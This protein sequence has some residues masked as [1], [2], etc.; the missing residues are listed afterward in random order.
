MA[1]ITIARQMGS[2]GKE[3]G[4]K[5]ASDWGY[6]Y[7]HKELIAEIARAAKVPE[8]RVE[9]MDEKGEGALKRF[10]KELFT[11]SHIFPLS[12]EYPAA[13]W[14]YIAASELIREQDSEDSGAQFLDRE[15]YLSL[16]RTTVTKLWERD[17]VII[18]GRGGQ[19]IL[20]DKANA[21]HVLIIAP[22]EVR[23]ERVMQEM[24]INR[25]D[26]LELLQKTDHQRRLYLQQNYDIGWTNP[27]HYHLVLNTAGLTIEQSAQIVEEA[28]LTFL[29]DDAGPVPS[30]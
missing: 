3:T 14:P 4:A 27:L 25:N 18:V 1:V 5:V 6:S 29:G 15:D 11:P 9:E 13:P 16:L 20:A 22:L 17:N 26:A 19:R 2:L 12:P 8:S 28:A 23:C 7:V 10:F 21:L 24:E 30:A